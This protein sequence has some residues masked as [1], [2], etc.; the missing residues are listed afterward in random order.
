VKN[1]FFLLFLFILTSLPAQVDKEKSYTYEEL[2]ALLSQA[3][4]LKDHRMLGDVYYLLSIYEEEV[5]SD[6]KKSFDYLTRSRERYALLEDS[7]EMYTVDERI[8]HR[9]FSAGFLNEALE[10]YEEML[11]YYQTS[12]NLFKEAHTLYKIAQVYKE[13]GDIDIEYQ[14]LNKA[15]DLNKTLKDT[16]LQ[17]NFMINQVEN[18]ERLN[19]LDSALY[20]CSE[21][22][23]LSKISNNV[24]S[25]KMGLYKVATINKR[26]GAY[27]NAI[28]YLKR[29]ID[30]GPYEPFDEHRLMVL[31]EL[32]D[33]YAKIENFDNAFRYSKSYASLNDSIL[34]QNRIEANYNYARKYESLRK[35]KDI[36]ELKIEKK[37][38]QQTNDQ[39]RRTLYVLGVGL[40]VLLLLIYY[41]IRFYN[42]QIKTEKIITDQREEI[43]Q[44][45][46]KELQD[47]IQIRSMQ[48]MIEGQELERERIAKDLHDSLGGLLSTVKLQFDSE[49][50]GDEVKR[51]ETFQR[52]HHLLDHAVTEVRTIS[53]NLQPAAL[54]NLG[55]EAALKDLINRFSDP[56]YP[57]IDLQCYDI[58]KEMNQII[59]LSIFRVIQEMLHN[60]IKHS[61]AN[62]ILIQI[63]R[64][65]DELVIQFE[66]DGVGF[67]PNKLK[68]KGMG[69]DN[70]KS[71]IDY[72][73]G[74]V[75]RDSRLGEGTSY[76]IH[77]SMK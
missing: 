45:Q 77:V 25:L 33:T 42:Q 49:Q 11:L 46:I 58:P 13:K 66:D 63:N 5:N 48:S 29:S 54:A 18:Y 71:R 53:Q 59:S 47:D 64:E 12:K 60:A 75:E 23:K 15:I 2:N 50:I 40:A 27:E 56:H 1:L 38:A 68:R 16:S 61:Q 20:I 31:R 6:L 10:K 8:A 69:L 34:N 76:L 67:D 70:I 21:V 74:T 24:E 35:Q 32:S 17:I 52:A 37:Y 7:L 22:I 14:F 19:E 41:I 26:T 28:K 62:E 3:R 43:N 72:L 73:K 4:V 39:Q 51:N 65:G 9:N 57:D 30:V 55:L 36:E 44:R